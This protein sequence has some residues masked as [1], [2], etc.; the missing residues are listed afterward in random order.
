MGTELES[1][2][3]FTLIASQILLVIKFVTRVNA[4]WCKKYDRMVSVFFGIQQL[5]V[6]QIL[7][8]WTRYNIMRRLS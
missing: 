3:Y 5:L 2:S 8:S 1:L 7:R 6:I 4:M